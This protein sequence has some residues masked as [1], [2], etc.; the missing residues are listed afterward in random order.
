MRLQNDAGLLRAAVSDLLH[1]GR[2]K[3]EYL[4][5]ATEAAGHRLS[6][7]CQTGL[8]VPGDAGVAVENHWWSGSWA[9]SFGEA[10]SLKLSGRGKKTGSPI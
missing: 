9:R 7:R 8:D 5:R 6:K 3:Y 4:L 10:E 2:P 1:L